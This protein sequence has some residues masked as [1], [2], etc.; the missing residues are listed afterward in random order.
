[1]GLA[2][3]SAIAAEVIGGVDLGR[4]WKHPG[5]VLNVLIGTTYTGMN[6]LGVTQYAQPVVAGLILIGAVGYDQFMKVR[7]KKDLQEQLLRQSLHP[8]EKGG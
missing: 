1:L 4:L 2:E 8:I 6:L 3:L 5:A 7:R